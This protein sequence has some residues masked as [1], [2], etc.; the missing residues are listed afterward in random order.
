MET[1]TVDLGERSYPIHIGAG[2]LDQAELLLPVIGKRQVCVITNEVVAPLYLKRLLATLAPCQPDHL[3]LPDGE[4][5]K[6]L[7]TVSRIYDHL[8]ERNYSRSCVLV[9]LGG[10]VIGDMVGF[11]AATYQRGVRFIQVPTTLLAQ[12]D[13]SVG[14]KTGVNRPLGKNMVGAFYQP[15]AVLIDVTTLDT[16]PPRELGAG[17]AEVIKYGCI[18]NRAFYDWLDTALPALLA[19][20]RAALIHAIKVSCQ[21]KAAIVA[22]DETEG[23][24]RATLNFGHTFGHAIETAQGYGNWLHGEAVATGMVMAADLSRRAGLLNAADARAIKHLIARAGLPV[25]PPPQLSPERFLTLMAKDK[26]A[27][28]GAIKFILLQGIGQAL[29]NRSV[30]PELLDATLNAGA[31]LAEY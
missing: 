7:D 9:A 13:S 27:E 5:H 21:E 18:N 25:A 12:V 11:A 23:G 19:R 24:V 1:L 15:Q 29:Y 2:L 16:L 10:G 30:P 22:A 31:R 8:L 28:R 17:L 3:I 26:K 6:T 4:E 20:E 14:G